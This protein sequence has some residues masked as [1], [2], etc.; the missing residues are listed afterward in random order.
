MYVYFFFVFNFFGKC[1]N[2][3]IRHIV[4]IIFRYWRVNYL[5]SSNR[6]KGFVFQYVSK[7][8]V[9]KR[10]FCIR[11]CYSSLNACNIYRGLS[12]CDIFEYPC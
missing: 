6:L 1:F 5:E 10:I 3:F 2:F 7:Y 11:L 12:I 4:D 9:Y 8:E